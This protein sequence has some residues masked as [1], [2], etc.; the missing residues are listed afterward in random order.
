MDTNTVLDDVL[1]VSSDSID[2]QDLIQEEHPVVKERKKP[3]PKPK[4]DKVAES[5]K[6]E[7]KIHS[8]E[9]E[10]PVGVKND[11]V[12]NVVLEK[13]T[14]NEEKS[15]DNSDSSE[16]S[17]NIKHENDIKHIESEIDADVKLNSNKLP[18]G[19]TFINPVVLYRSPSDKLPLCK[20]SFVRFTGTFTNG[21]AKC[22]TIISGQG[23]TYGYVKANPT[24]LKL[25]STNE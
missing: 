4:S 7:V 3:G 10:P 5:N 6:P 23:R 13:S 15:S 18:S 21:Y 24:I 14:S 16:S 8:A 9:S 22:F 11:I 2:K 25:L 20:V 19:Y 17:D 12:N 1:G